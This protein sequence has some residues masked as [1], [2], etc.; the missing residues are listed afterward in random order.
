MAQHLLWALRINCNHCVPELGLFVHHPRGP[1]L[2]PG[3]PVQEILSPTR[4]ELPIS[5]KCLQRY[6]LIS[7]FLVS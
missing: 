2:L 6:P 5:M 4:A 7:L 1:A 3:V